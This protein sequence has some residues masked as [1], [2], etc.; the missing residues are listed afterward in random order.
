MASGRRGCSRPRSEAGLGR[1]GRSGRWVLGASALA[2]DGQIRSVR[3]DASLERIDHRRSPIDARHRRP[4]ARRDR[5][6]AS[7]SSC[8]RS[9]PRR[10]SSGRASRPL[11]AFAVAAA[12]TPQRRELE[13]R[14][15]AD[16][17]GMRGASGGR[18]V[19]RDVAAGVGRRCATRGQRDPVPAGRRR[20]LALASTRRRRGLAVVG[21][22]RPRAADLDRGSGCGRTRMAAGTRNVASA[23]AD[24]QR[25]RAARSDRWGRRALALASARRREVGVAAGEALELLAWSPG[26]PTYRT[27]WSGGGVDAARPRRR[28]WQTARPLAMDAGRRSSPSFE[29]DGCELAPNGGSRRSETGGRAISR[30][31][32]SPTATR[33]RSAGRGTARRRTPPAR[34]R[35]LPDQTPVASSSSATTGLI[36]VCQTTACEPSSRIVTSLSTTWYR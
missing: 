23:R 3:G 24:G 31:R 29:F 22:R 19:R 5:L 7:R 14:E 6:L 2:A 21:R 26:D 34:A 33:T 4:R 28:A 30:P 27:A 1:V 17:L 16:R 13:A 10:T 12:L 9:T 36:A 11:P 35:P 18:L 32:A 15:L 8:G 20:A 25:R